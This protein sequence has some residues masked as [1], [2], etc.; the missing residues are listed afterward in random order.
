[1]TS[2]CCG[3]SGGSIG[4]CGHRGRNT[5]VV[6]AVV[7]AGGMMGGLAS[8]FSRGVDSASARCSPADTLLGCGFFLRD[9]VFLMISR[10]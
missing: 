10:L 7:V 1:M 4:N 3:G 2:R 6:V 5:G 8:P 9:E